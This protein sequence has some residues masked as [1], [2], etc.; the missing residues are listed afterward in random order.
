MFRQIPKFVLQ[1]LI[2]QV[3]LYK[4]ISPNSYIDMLME[5]LGT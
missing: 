3:V 2:E 1:Y 5:Q 4:L